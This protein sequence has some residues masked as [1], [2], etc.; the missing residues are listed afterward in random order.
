MQSLEGIDETACIDWGLKGLE[1]EEKET[2]HLIRRDEIGNSN[3]Y[4][5][6]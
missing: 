1:I 2:S 5:L 3:E 6:V 4:K